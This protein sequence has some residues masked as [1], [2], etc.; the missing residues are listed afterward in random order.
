MILGM[1]TTRDLLT[2]L[3]LAGAVAGC[4]RPTVLDPEGRALAVISTE[5]PRTRKGFGPPPYGYW[6]IVG[7]PMTEDAYAMEPATAAVSTM[8]WTFVGGKPVRNEYWSGTNDAGGRIVSI[9]CH[10]TIASVAYAASASGGIWKTTDS[11]ANWTPLTDAQ[12][13]LNHGA[14]EIDRA[15]PET[16][17]A[18]TGEYTTGSSGTGL[19]RSLDDGSTWSLLST[20]S[21]ADCSGLAVV[22]GS[23][24]ASPAAIHATGSSGY[25]RS[26][27]GGTTWSTLISSNCSSL[28]VDPTNSQRVFVAVRGSGIRRSTNGGATFTTLT[29]G[30]PTSGFSRIV[31]AIARSNPQVLYAAFVNPSTSGLLGM[32]RTTD[33]G[34]TWTQLAGT[35]DFP[36]P[37][38]WYDLSIGVDPANPDHLYCGGVSPIYATAGVIESFNG[39]ATWTEIS[40]SGGQIHPDQH[41]IAFGADGT[42]WFGCDGGVW[43]RTGAQWINCNATLAA[44]QNY[45]I[46]QHPL[47]PNRMMGGTQDNGMAG[48]SNGSL[49][50]PQITAGD[51]GFGAYDPVALNRLYTTYVYLVIYRVTNG[52]AANISGPWSGDTREWIAPMVIDPGNANRLVAGTNRIWITDNA[53]SGSTWTAVSTT[54]VSDGGTVTAIEVVQGLSSVIWAGNSA[55]GIFQST[56]AGTTWVRRRAAD[57]TYISAIDARPG[58]ASVAFATRL[59]SSGTRLLRTVDGSNWTAASGSLPTGIT[60]QALA[61]DWGRPLPTVYVGAGS[62]IYATFDGAV[63]WIKDGVDLPNVNIGQLQVDAQRRTVIAG[64]YGRGAWRSEMPNIADI[65]LDGAVTGADLGV[66]LGEWGPCTTTNW[67]CRSDLN[68]DGTVGGADLGLLLGQWTS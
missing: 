25:R 45:T 37:Q 29:G 44:I 5:S 10:P 6:R 8:A 4:A 57:G 63:S 26:T 48:T 68:Q 40:S 49:A 19:L 23:A 12:P 20:Q 2:A 21:G 36:R 15:F 46:A 51:G 14:V 22:S 47:D 28:A 7:E 52:S 11:G 9:A 56:D 67:G 30:L 41:W 66:L 43:R 54:E 50:W 16:I 18:G 65:T 13:S 62:G 38:G 42:P 17:Y 39:G 1:L 34:S 60:A 33:G 58:S 55:G 32:Y 35:P 24:A 27:D 3:S 59:A 53:T 64:T 61:V 31:L